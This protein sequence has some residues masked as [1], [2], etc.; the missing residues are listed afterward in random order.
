M[1]GLYLDTKGLPI[2]KSQMADF[3]VFGSPRITTCTETVAPFESMPEDNTTYS[4]IPNTTYTYI[5]E[6]EVF[7][8][9]VLCH[10]LTKWM[11]MRVTIPASS[12]IINPHV[13]LSVIIFLSTDTRL[14]LTL[15]L[16]N[17]Y[18]FI[19]NLMSMLSS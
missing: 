3:P 19:L 16:A 12:R 13:H 8:E 14:F 10:F 6:R 2:R 11:M 7:L 18:L 15:N 4:D 9:R 17:D 1:V 5:I